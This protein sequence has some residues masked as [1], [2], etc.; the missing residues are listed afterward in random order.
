MTATASSRPRAPLTEL[1]HNALSRTKSEGS[2]GLQRFERLAASTN[3]D[4]C[5]THLISSPYPDFANQLKLEKSGSSHGMRT[6][7]NNNWICLRVR[8]SSHFVITVQACWA[9]QS[10]NLIV[11]S[12]IL[13]RQFAT[14]ANFSSVIRLL[15][16]C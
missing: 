12:S 4:L 6:E 9:G 13:V 16:W 5:A 8:H 15:I 2:A 10:L 7:I 14:T 11:L 3:I 1:Q